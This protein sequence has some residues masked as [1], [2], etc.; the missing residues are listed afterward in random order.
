MFVL[1]GMPD[2][3][4]L[5]LFVNGGGEKDRPKLSGVTTEPP[6]NPG[7]TKCEHHCKTE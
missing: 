1:C 7:V 3:R 6:G 5:I 4:V 2:F